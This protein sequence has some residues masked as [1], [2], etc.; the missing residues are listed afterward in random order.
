MAD[1]EVKFGADTAG[2]DAGVR[3]VLSSLQGLKEEAPD[4][5]GAGASG[6]LMGGN[7]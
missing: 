6:F 3:Q 5:G 4:T 1:V 7:L 2:V